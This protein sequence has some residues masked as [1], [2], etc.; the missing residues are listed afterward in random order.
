MGF[1]RVG[2]S[3]R[4]LIS[5]GVARQMMP[6]MSRFMASDF[7]NELERTIRGEFVAAENH[8][9]ATLPQ[10]VGFTLALLYFISLLFVL[11]ISS[12]RL[13]RYVSTSY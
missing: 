8:Q 11:I 12:C 4:R 3:K 1:C 7:K 5:K 10:N 2:A 9:G 13:M 6:M